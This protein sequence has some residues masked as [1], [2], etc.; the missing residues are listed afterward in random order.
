[1][2]VNTHIEQVRTRARAEQGA[3]DGRRDAYEI[4]IHRVQKLQPEQTPP[5][6]AGL[7]TAGGATHLS[8]GAS[9]TPVRDYPVRGP[10]R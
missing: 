2:A 5:S 1:M 10:D 3:I 7:T 4:F 6:V 9:S 8:A